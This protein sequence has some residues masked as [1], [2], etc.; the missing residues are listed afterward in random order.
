MVC[1]QMHSWKGESFSRSYWSPLITC[2]VSRILPIIR[3]TLI[4]LWRSIT[5]CITQR[6]QRRRAERMIYS[7]FEN[8]DLTSTWSNLL[9][10]RNCVDER[11]I[12]EKSEENKEENSDD[13][14]CCVDVHGGKIE[15]LEIRDHFFFQSERG[16]TSDEWIQRRNETTRKTEK[17][18][19]KRLVSVG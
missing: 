19:I 8:E 1:A 15:R 7:R 3:K 5:Q 16:F 9:I 11:E 6:I 10:G 4:K 2:L 13:N 12:S 14:N 18:F 17:K